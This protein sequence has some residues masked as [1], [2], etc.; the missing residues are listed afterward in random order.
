MCLSV[1]CPTCIPGGDVEESPDLRL[2]SWLESSPRGRYLSV[3]TTYTS[4]HWLIACAQYNSNHIL[5]LRVLVHLS[6][7]RL[8]VVSWNM[9]GS[10]CEQHTW[11]YFEC[12]FCQIHDCA[13][14]HLPAF[15]VLNVFEKFFVYST[16]AHTAIFLSHTV[17][18]QS[19]NY[20]SLTGL[21]VI[22]SHAPTTL[23]WLGDDCYLMHRLQS[24]GWPYSKGGS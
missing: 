2:E 18:E 11:Y 12:D 21:Y 17:Y 14:L 3:G 9:H 4:A 6:T 22:H 1:I 15:V 16:N 20:I 19:T 24:H 23:G 8:L 5:I 13:H 10:W 7:S